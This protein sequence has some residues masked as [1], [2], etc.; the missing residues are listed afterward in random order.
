[1]IK[2]RTAVGIVLCSTTF[3][4]AGCEDSAAQQR[5]AVQKTISQISRELSVAMSG[6]SGADEG[7]SEQK[8]NAVLSKLNAVSGGEAG[9]QA[10]KAMLAASA[11]QQLA[12]IHLG[13]AQAI[14][15]SHADLR[16]MLN[17]KVDAVAT[18]SGLAANRGA[19]DIKPQ[20]DALGEQVESAQNH[21]EQLQGKIAELDGP[22]NERTTQNQANQQEVDR[23]RVEV[24]ELVSKARDLGASSGL[25]TFNQATERRRQADKI[26]FEI[27]NR[28]IELDYDLTPD[29]QMASTQLEQLQGMIATLGET[30][31]GLQAMSQAAA[32]DAET[33]KKAV[34]ALMDEINVGLGMLTSETDGPLKTEYDEAISMLEKAGT[35]AD[36]AGRQ[37]KGEDAQAARMMAARIRESIGRA[38]WSQGRA[39]ADQKALL[40]RLVDSGAEGSASFKS[41]LEAAESAHAEAVAKATEAFTAA[42]EA[43]QQVQSKSDPQAVAAFQQNLETAM[44]SLQSKGSASA[45]VEEAPAGA[46]STDDATAD[47]S[48]ASSTEMIAEG[49]GFD[50]PEALLEHVNTIAGNGESFGR[51]LMAVIPISRAS[52]PDGQTALKATTGLAQAIDTIHGAMVEKFG[53]D[54]TTAAM[55]ALGMKNSM[56]TFDVAN[57]TD[58]TDTS[59]KIS[60]QSSSGKTDQMGLMVVDG[61]WFLSTDPQDAEDRQEAAMLAP[62]VSMMKKSAVDVAKRIKAGEFATADE[63]MKAFQTGMI[64]GMSG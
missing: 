15:A 53:L 37:L 46:G 55:T 43:A 58:R 23:L 5:D 34:A 61:Q 63:A 26:E 35:Q 36:G 60:F 51:Q 9:Q 13:K 3:M 44:A 48:A 56:P 47:E 6:A 27:S 52:T 24:G 10:A 59:A 8:L 32:A 39:W 22:I 1:M 4:A 41:P 62:M 29:H 16:A 28:E 19:Y 49:T 64:P 31:D 40:Q 25:S 50:T 2:P 11:Q 14:Q 45:A 20:I 38:Y 17:A 18:L 57:I 12:S 30:R 21:V 54:A 42:Q 33:S 7:Q